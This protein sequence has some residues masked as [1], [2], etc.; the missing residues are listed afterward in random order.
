MKATLLI[1]TILFISLNVQSQNKVLELD[2]IND[3]VNLGNTPGNNLRTT[4][5]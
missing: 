5:F 2:G 3:Y 4:E 1:F